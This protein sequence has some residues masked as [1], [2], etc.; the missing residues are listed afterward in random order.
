MKDTLYNTM[1]DE[2]QHNGAG[3]CEYTSQLLPAGLQPVMT[4]APAMPTGLSADLRA[5]AALG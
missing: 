1:D 5:L 2:G 4:D 3:A